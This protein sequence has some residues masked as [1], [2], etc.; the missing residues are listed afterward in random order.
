MRMFVPTTLVLGSLL[1][2]T[3]SGWAAEPSPE[4]AKAIAE[5][6]KL[7]GTV[8]VFEDRPRT[9]VIVVDLRGNGVTD[10]GVVH[11]QGLSQLQH[12]SLWDTQVT[13]AGLMHLQGL[14]Q[15]RSLDLD[16]GLE[17]L[18]GLTQLRILDLSGTQVADAGL[19]HLE[20][21]T[22][23]QWLRLVGTKVTDAGVRELQKALPNAHIVRT[24]NRKAK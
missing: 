1:A 20:G 24:V 3:P 5:I 17:R 14:T 8:R 16:P 23:L 6:R 13:D 7:G 2:A 12:L 18:K 11:L 9:P 4:Q 22:R 10:A 21:L 15:L 19:V